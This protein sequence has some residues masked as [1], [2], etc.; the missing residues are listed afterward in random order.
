[1]GV[2]IYTCSRFISYFTLGL[3]TK[4]AIYVSKTAFVAKLIGTGPSW[5]N[6]A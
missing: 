4:L 1:M 3:S 5:G 6:V 2:L